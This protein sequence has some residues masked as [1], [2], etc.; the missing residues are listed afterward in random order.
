MDRGAQNRQP[1]E[2]QQDVYDM[3]MFPGSFY[4]DSIPFKSD[5]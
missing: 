1:Q 2:T 3:K 4:S 5:G